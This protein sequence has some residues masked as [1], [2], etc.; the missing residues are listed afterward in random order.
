MSNIIPTGM[1]GLSWNEAQQI[2][3]ELH[4]EKNRPDPIKVNGRE[5]KF[6]P[7]QYRPYPVAMYHETCGIQ[8]PKLVQTEAERRDLEASGWTIEPTEMQAAN[9]RYLDG[10]A[11]QAAER[12]YDDQHMS[13]K[14]RSEF[15]AADVANG[16]DHLLDLPA[17]K[18]K[19]GRPAKSPAS[20]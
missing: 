8:Q 17:P 18:K 10:I 11:Q 20:A 4:F 16:E 3:D 14:A 13:E 12:A 6:P 2:A 19:P 1:E 7:Y 5:L 9:T 15:H